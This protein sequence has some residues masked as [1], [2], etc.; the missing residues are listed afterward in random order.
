ME[1]LGENRK[2]LNVENENGNGGKSVTPEG[3]RKRSGELVEILKESVNNTRDK[4]K[5]D[6]EL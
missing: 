5:A 2:R 6:R 3:K 1:R 4:N